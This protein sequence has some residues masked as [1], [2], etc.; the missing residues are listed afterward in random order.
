VA[1]AVAADLEHDACIFRLECL[2]GEKIIHRHNHLDRPVFRRQLY[3][4]Q[5]MANIAAPAEWPQARKS[6]RNC[7]RGPEDDGTEGSGT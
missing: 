6:P 3:E 4:S 2:G 7:K 1:E 5:T